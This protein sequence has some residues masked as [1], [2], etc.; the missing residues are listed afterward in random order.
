MGWSED[1]KQ[2]LHYFMILVDLLEKIKWFAE[3]ED[4]WQNQKL[5]FNNENSIKRTSYG[6]IAI[7][8]KKRSSQKKLKRMSLYS[9]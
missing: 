5:W 6:I 4:T 8:Y 9:N 3:I 1:P 2:Q 7:V